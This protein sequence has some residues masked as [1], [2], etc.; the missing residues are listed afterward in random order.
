MIVRQLEVFLEKFTGLS[1]LLYHLIL[2]LY[3][4]GILLSS[5]WNRKA[6]LWLSGRRK[7]QINS[8]K[9]KTIWMH[10]SS[11]GEFEQ[12]RPVLEAIRKAY[13]SY[14]A[15]V[16]FFSPSGYE[17][18]KNYA[19]ADEV[20]YLP[21]DGP[22]N[23]RKLVEKL[24]PAL[25][26]WVKYEY[27][28]YYLNELHKRKVPVLLVS[29][30]FR[31][32]Q[33]FFKW[34]GALWRHMLS[35]FS[36]LFV[37]QQESVRLVSAIGFDK[38]V[39]LS[40]DTRFDRVS[41]IAA[42]AKSL[43]LIELFCAGSKTFVA[44]STW[45]EDEEELTHYVKKHPEIRFIIAPHEVDEE[46]IDEIRAE[47]PQHIC[48]SAMTE[49]MVIPADIN[50]LIIDNIGMLSRLYRYADIC[51]VGG[52]FGADGIHNVLEAAVYGKPVLFGPVFEKFHEAKG[53]VEAGGGFSVSH[54]VELEKLLDEFFENREKLEKAGNAAGDFVRRNC[55][56]TEKILTYVKE[57]RLLTN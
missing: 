6:R 3:Q 52:G 4:A 38:E 48:F 27:W 40:G 39:S 20:I 31:E 15:V 19:G 47:F 25:V 32:S 51:F 41:A 11:L 33:P 16:S 50:V 2:L 37:Q 55:G 8:Y 35:C 46:R 53:L 5:P 21:M 26:I 9:E 17:I 28:Y 7:Q 44:G 13:P 49:H 18:R 45:E 12:G 14:K 10:C 56:A 1:L 43:P 42:E 29:G 24:N 22:V 34:Y 36:H 30:I 54:A 23:A 57:N